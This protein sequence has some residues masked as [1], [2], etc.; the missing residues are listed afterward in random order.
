MRQGVAKGMVCQTRAVA[1]ASA[2][3][4]VSCTALESGGQSSGFEAG[5]IHTVTPHFLSL[6]MAVQRY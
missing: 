1:A 4:P 6:K 2:H 5:M 3:T